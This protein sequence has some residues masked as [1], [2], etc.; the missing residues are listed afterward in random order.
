MD[1]LKELKVVTNVTGDTMLD[2]SEICNQAVNVNMK[3]SRL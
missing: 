3:S 1:D 2:D